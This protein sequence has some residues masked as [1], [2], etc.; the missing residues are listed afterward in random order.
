M[1]RTVWT[2]G[3]IAG[4]IL[5]IMMLIT[6]PFADRIGFDKSLIVGYTSMVL[7]FLMIFFGVKSYRDNMGGG[8]ISFGRALTIG[9]LITVIASVCYVATWLVINYTMMP[10]F[11]DKYAAYAVEQ[12]R[13]SG[14]SQAEIDAKAKEMEHMKVML[15]NPVTNAASTFLEPLPVGVL[16]ALISAAILRRKRESEPRLTTAMGAS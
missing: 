16:L 3:L 9:L 13:K 5:S 6:V 2:F 4:A 12:V 1:R 15:K 14:A 7:G 8:S 11:A 10:D